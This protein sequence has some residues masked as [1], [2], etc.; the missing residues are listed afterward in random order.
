MACDGTR[1]PQHERGDQCS[2]KRPAQK[3]D[4]AER[5][6]CHQSSQRSRCRK[7]VPGPEQERLAGLVHHRE[8]RDVG[9]GLPLEKIE[10]LGLAGIASRR[11]GRPGDRGLRGVRWQQR[12][13]DALGP[14]PLEV[15]QLPL[16]HPLLDEPGIRAVE[17][18]D[19]HPLLR[20][21]Q[22][23]AGGQC[24]GTESDEE[25]TRRVVHCG[26]AI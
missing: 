7:G 25:G 12:G 4:R 21:C 20:R 14:E 10:D 9:V 15:R 8:G 19:D 6:E 23:H 18:D 24:R 1:G 17:A 22:T 2:G 13:V 16:V 11:E 26:A 3:K 5:Q